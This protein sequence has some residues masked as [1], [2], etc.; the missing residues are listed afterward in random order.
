MK[1]NTELEEKFRL[2]TPNQMAKSKLKHGTRIENSNHILDLVQLPSVHHK[3]I[4]KCVLRKLR[5]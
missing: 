2:K 5:T 4:Q 1:I 3:D